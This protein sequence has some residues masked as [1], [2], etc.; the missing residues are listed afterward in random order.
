MKLKMLLKTEGILRVSIPVKWLIF[1]RE[2]HYQKLHNW[3]LVNSSKD[4]QEIQEPGNTWLPS[5]IN[6]KLMKV[7][8]VQGEWRG[9]DC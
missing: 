7:H 1:L 5:R 8:K 3:K 4:L 6:R 2:L 9:R